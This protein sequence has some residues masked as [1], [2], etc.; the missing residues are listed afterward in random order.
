MTTVTNQPVHHVAEELLPDWFRKERS[1]ILTDPDLEIRI[2]DGS[3]VVY[4]MQRDVRTVDN[5][6]LLLASHL[7]TSRKLPLRVVY[8]LPPPPPA[9]HGDDDGLPPPLVNMRMTSRHGEFLLG[10]L[11]LVHRELMDMKIPLHVLQASS[12]RTVGEKFCQCV[13]ED[14]QA[15]V[16]VSDF[17][18]LR[19]FREWME[20]QATPL[21]QRSSIPFYQVDT[22]NIVPV[23]IATQKREVGARTLRPRIHRVVQDYLQ[24]FPEVTP[25]SVD[26]PLPKFDRE[27]YGTYLQMDKSVEP[28]D[29]AKPGT[30]A[31]MQQFQLFL[32]N[33]LKPYLFKFI[34]LD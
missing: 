9:S 28:V 19:E 30:E 17:S 4:W 16:V 26:V 15:C 32:R 6:A 5:Y 23:W 29:W 18:P 25:N 7:A 31:A 27:T 24:D 20:L 1:R 34:D 3:S 13:L 21:L 8:V 14:L 11:E 22:H 10:G 33:G 12:H 2:N